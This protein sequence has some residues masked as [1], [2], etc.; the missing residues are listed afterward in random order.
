MKLVLKAV[1]SSDYQD[2]IAIY[3]EVYWGD[4]F[5]QERHP[6]FEDGR[7]RFIGRLDGQPVC[8]F[9]VNAYEIY[10]NGTKYFC[11]G[12][13]AV[14]VIPAFRKYGI[15]RSMMQWAI[16]ELIRQGFVIANLYGFRE[17]YYRGFGYEVAGCR[18]EIRCPSERLPKVKSTL[19]SRKIDPEDAHQILGECYEK[20][21]SQHNGS[22]SRNEWHWQTRMGIN[23][24]VIYAFGDPVEGY[25]W[26]HTDQGFWEELNFGEV[27]Y[28]TPEGYRAFL[29]FAR[30]LAINQKTVVW[31]ESNSGPFATMHQDQGVDV[32]RVRP[33]MY[34]LLNPRKAI[35]DAIE[36]IYITDQFN[37]EKV[38]IPADKLSCSIGVLT[39][40]WLGEPS[41]TNL[42]QNGQILGTPE[43][44]EE[45]SSILP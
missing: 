28:S 23:P 19:Q 1:D 39:Q 26:A 9:T 3:G 31:H 22:N 27:V 32:T 42:V 44:I 33:A 30:S 13:A 7:L 34:R 25:C 4:R 35:G 37:T 6:D 15:G 24:P 21:A 40:A 38:E 12:I 5:P 10:R 29:E 43:L 18:N 17:T 8:S 20:F 41:F 14:G 11:A 16:V 2:F 45:F 36:K